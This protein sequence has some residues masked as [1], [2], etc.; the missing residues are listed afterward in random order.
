M[1]VSKGTS[2]SIVTTSLLFFVNELAL[3]SI[4]TSALYLKF[5]KKPFECLLVICFYLTF[6]WTWSAISVSTGISNLEPAHVKTIAGSIFL[7][8]TLTKYLSKPTKFQILCIAGIFLLLIKSTLLSSNKM[9][10]IKYLINMYIPMI[11]TI[12]IMGNITFIKNR[13]KISSKMET[14]ITLVLTVSLIGALMHIASGYDTLIS[15]TSS[16]ADNRQDTDIILKEVDGVFK[17]FTAGAATQIAGIPVI[18]NPG[19][20]I[21][22]ILAGYTLAF[23]TV[24]IIYFVNKHKIILLTASCF[25]LFITFSKGAWIIPIITIFIAE[26]NKFFWKKSAKFRLITNILLISTISLATIVSASRGSGDSSFIHF[27]GLSQVFVFHTSVAGNDLGSGGNYAESEFTE[28]L[29]TGAESTIGVMY[30]HIG[31]AGL[32]LFLAL[33]ASILMSLLKKKDRRYS[34]LIGM[35]AAQLILCFLQ[36]NTYNLAYSFPRILIF[37]AIMFEINRTNTHADQKNI[38]LSHNG[39]GCRINIPIHTNTQKVSLT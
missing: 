18:R 1:K 2:L 28:K 31:A 9:I 39:A 12:V 14:Y 37:I 10:A 16:L 4:I 22:S 34:I 5:K 19:L 25:L 7:A 30:Y 27:M 32:A 24:Y 13:E 11:I 26:T 8:I 3:L 15:L 20:I 29:K 17:S 33:N 6:Q 35:L 21:D 38:P 23:T 36:E